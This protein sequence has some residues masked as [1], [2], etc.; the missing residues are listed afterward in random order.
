M[1]YSGIKA[2][3]LCCYIFGTF[4]GQ[5]GNKSRAVVLPEGT[6]L[7]SFTDVLKVAYSSGCLT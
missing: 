5:N 2:N 1:V 3:K 6:L 4:A 7:G